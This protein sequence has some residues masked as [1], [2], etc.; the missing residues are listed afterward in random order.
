MP[1]IEELFGLHGRVA[2]VT[3][4]TGVLGGA[5]CKAL[6]RAGAKVAILGRKRDV[7]EKL[8]AQIKSDGGSAMAV[9]A[10]VLNISELR[11]ARQQIEKQLGAVHILINGA[12]GNIPVAVVPPDK[13]FFGMDVQEFKNVFDL[14]LTGTVITTQV[15]AEGMAAA[16]KGV[17][18]NISSVTATRAL[19]RVAGYGA[20]KA[21][22]NNFTQWLAVELAKKHGEGIRVNAIAPGF[23]LTAQN[24]DLLTNPDG[25][26]TERGQL[27]LK[28][29]PF[30]RFGN[31]EELC[32]TLL[33]LCSDASSFVTGVVVHVDGGYNAY[34]GI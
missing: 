10:D 9:V 32:G 5:L 34:G 4:G 24:K 27:I 14:N 21:A 8:A 22:V 15:F 25:S 3:G 29:T 11:S 23:Y 2:V 6:A 31:P 28:A 16:K 20:A 33:W 13:T 30:G 12:G 7:A 1:Y 26:L 17:I 19:T 18:V